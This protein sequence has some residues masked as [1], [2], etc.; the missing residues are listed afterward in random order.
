[1]IFGSIIDF[2]I[3]GIVDALA[4]VV[5]VVC[6]R[7]VVVGET[8]VVLKVAVGSVAIMLMDTDVTSW[9]CRLMDDNLNFDNRNLDLKQPLHENW[10]GD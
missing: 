7:N 4:A 6:Y 2:Y 1:M 3:L 9:L 5:A 8:V 10:V